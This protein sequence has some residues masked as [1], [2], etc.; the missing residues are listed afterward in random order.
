[1]VANVRGLSQRAFFGAGYNNGCLRQPCG[2]KA[3]RAQRRATEPRLV[4]VTGNSRM[5]SCWVP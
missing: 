4:T 1:M 3:G 5:I 2:W